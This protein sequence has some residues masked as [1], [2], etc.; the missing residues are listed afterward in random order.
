MR[1]PATTTSPA[2]E[3]GFFVNEQNILRAV[4]RPLDIWRRRKT[5]VYAFPH[6]E[7]K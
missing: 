5:N 3:A 1:A 2:F 4:G 7:V 6:F